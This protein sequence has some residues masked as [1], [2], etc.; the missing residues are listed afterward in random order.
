MGPGDTVAGPKWHHHDVIGLL[1]SEN[2]LFDYQNC[3]KIANN[4]QIDE[5]IGREVG[6]IKFSK[7]H[8]LNSDLHD[9]NE[10]WSA[11]NDDFGV[12]KWCLKIESFWENRKC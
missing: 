9:S 4:D 11:S 7:I 5:K 10:L 3:Y 2:D 12:K 1:Q 6:L 8:Y